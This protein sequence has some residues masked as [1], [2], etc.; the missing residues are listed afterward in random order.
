MTR[1]AVRWSLLLLVAVALW[2]GCGGATDAADVDAAGADTALTDA[3]DTAVDAASCAPAPPA[4]GTVRARPLEC[5][6]DLPHG[7]HAAALPGDL[8]LE[9]AV[10][11]FV[12]RAGPQGYAL[13]G[14]PGGHLIDAV[15]LEAGVQRGADSLRELALT[16]DFWLLVPDRVEITDDGSEGAARVRVEGHLAGFPLIQSVLPLPAPD[17]DVAH[18]YVLVPDSPVLEIRTRLSP[19]EAG[20]G[21]GVL[22]ADVSLWGADVRL[23]IPGL[24][25]DA[26]PTSASGAVLGLT[27]SRAG[28]DTPACAIA[29]EAPR[30][31][32]DASGIK[33]FLF[34]DTPVP[35]GGVTV[36]RRLAV[37]GTQ[38]TDLAHAMAALDLPGA[39]PRARALGVVQGAFAGL[40]VEALDDAGHPLTRCAVEAGRFDCP[41]P[42]ATAALVPRW[43]GDGDGDVGLGDQRAGEAAPFTP[44]AETTLTAAPARLEVQ[45]DDPVG[46]PVP[47]RLDAWS[48]AG[49]DRRTF[50][51]ADG[52]AT[53]LL[54]P[55]S[56]QLWLH[57]GPRWSEA[58]ETLTLAPGATARFEATLRRVVDTGP[59]VAV[60]LHVHAEDSTDSEAANTHRFAAALAEDLVGYVATD[61][62]FVTDAAAWLGASG[63]ADRLEVAAGVEVSTTAL[64]H[65]NV[66]PVAPDPTLAGQGA[67]DWDGLDA[68]GLLARL[69]AAAP[70]GVVQLNHPRFGGASYFDAIG[71]DPATT[72]PALLAF[73]A[74]E[75]ING[76]GHTD[77]PEVL[78]DWT[79]LLDRGLR[80]TGTGASDVHGQ[81]EPMGLPGTLVRPETDGDVWEALRAGRAVASAGPWL[82]V[83]L[84]DA[85]GATGR[86]GDTLVAP[87][88]PL[89]L[90]AALEAPDWLSLGRLR[91]LVSG[92][93]LLDEDVSAEPVVDGR[94]R[95]MRTLSLPA[96]ADAWCVAVHLPGDTPRPGLRRPPWAVTNPVFVDADGDGHVLPRSR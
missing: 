91:V 63:L 75:L 74:M 32:V 5:A 95:V 89:L 4:P 77:T 1:G 72:D 24:G 73:D 54:P 84:S 37:G 64:G 69:R 36:V 29:T 86:I 59:W 41:V 70:T 49:D 10:S 65:F 16:A 81:G 33:A 47:F 57:H 9:N 50:V 68:P 14:L 45:V 26:L 27:P 6:A 78:A 22:L 31:L 46:Q 67:P 38:G 55:G 7:L 43:L 87:A 18:E 94:R 52:A 90:T 92:E 12:V 82:T 25:A 76:I 20:P 23:F 2:P 53:F 17:V 40:E 48:S 71:F 34:P 21:P 61:H 58:T 93:T 66:W 8:V 28:S 39:P 51:S 62:D 15:R 56:W 42:Q 88:G 83:E 3:A 60:D 80:I 96:D 85:Q 11:R 44:D 19:R 30:T 79:G 13:P 35:A